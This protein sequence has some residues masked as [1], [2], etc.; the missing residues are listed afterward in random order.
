MLKA[1]DLPRIYEELSKELPK[2]AVQKGQTKKVKGYDTIGYGYQFCIN[3]MNEVLGLGHWRIVARN[4]SVIERRYEK[5]LMYECIYQTK[6]LIGNYVD[7]K[8]VRLAETPFV[9]GNHISKN[10]G[11][12]HKGA[13]TNSLKKAL[14]FFGVGKKAYEG[15]LDD[16]NINDGDKFGNQQGDQQGYQQYGKRSYQKQ[17]KVSSINENNNDPPSKSED[18]SGSV[19]FQKLIQSKANDSGTTYCKYQGYCIETGESLLFVTVGQY[20]VNKRYLVT[21]IQDRGMIMVKA[22]KEDA[23]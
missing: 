13:M 7:G 12:A 8:F 6:V 23:A 20:D 16:D 17:Q 10:I 9:P 3:R 4:L 5:T 14:A 21:G 18:F 1:E 22:I 2:E 19:F 11:D 15:S